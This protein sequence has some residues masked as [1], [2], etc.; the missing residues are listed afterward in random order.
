MCNLDSL[1]TIT[2]FAVAFSVSKLKM[3]GC[4]NPEMIGTM[5]TDVHIIDLQ[6]NL[7]SEN[8]PVVFLSM[9]S[10]KS[11][12]T[13]RNITVVLK[14]IRPVRWYLESWHIEGSLKVISNNGPVEDH[15]LSAGQDLK[16]EKKALPDDFQQ[17]W[18]TVISET[19]VAPISYIR[20]KGANVITIVVSPENV[21]E[22]QRASPVLTTSGQEM[23]SNYVPDRISLGDF[24]GSRGKTGFP[25]VETKTE[26][27]STSSK[28]T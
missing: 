17:L 26:V 2:D 23:T 10:E 14:S 18:R 12:T 15:S 4:F 7:L 5:T 6:N 21:Q 24:K 13:S 19:Q 16:I 27:S 25:K 20:V 1:A 11:E 22:K 28:S 9:T 3:Q 8:L